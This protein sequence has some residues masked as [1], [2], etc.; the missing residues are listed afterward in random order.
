MG[1]E[2]Q[3]AT[4]SLSDQSEQQPA[5]QLRGCA[6]R[7]EKEETENGSSR[8]QLVRSVEIFKNKCLIW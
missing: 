7:E 5:V 3:F 6:E 4:F 8:S 1:D 2:P